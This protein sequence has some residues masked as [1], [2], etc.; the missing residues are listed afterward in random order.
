MEKLI[1]V[2]TT[3]TAVLADDTVKILAV[4]V[5]FQEDRDG[6]TFGNGKFGSIY[7]QNYGNDILDPLAAR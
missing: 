1:H 2:Q 6:A 3:Q 7:S 4:M 5:N